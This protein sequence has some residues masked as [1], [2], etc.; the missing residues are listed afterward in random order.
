[1]VPGSI[2]NLH[3]GKVS[4]Q[5]ANAANHHSDRHGSEDYLNIV[6]RLGNEVHHS[7]EINEYLTYF[8]SAK[9][10]RNNRQGDKIFC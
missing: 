5:M 1:M 8:T 10:G 9:V 3:E 2:R 7:R 6:H 4:G